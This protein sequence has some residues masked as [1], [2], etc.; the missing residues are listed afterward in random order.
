MPAVS[1]LPVAS[2]SLGLPPDSAAAAASSAQPTQVQSARGPAR[3]AQPA[4]AAAAEE[5]NSANA[6]HRRAA[7]Q[8]SNSG[9]HDNFDWPTAQQQPQSQTLL[10]TAQQ[11]VQSSQPSATAQAASQPSTSSPQGTPA[12]GGSG[13]SP[14]HPAA[15][16][17]L[18]QRSLSSASSDGG[19]PSASP[20]PLTS[21][22]SGSGGVELPPDTTVYMQGLLTKKGR[23]LGFGLGFWRTTRLYM[24]TDTYLGWTDKSQKTC[25]TQ[26]AVEKFKAVS[27]L[28]SRRWPN[29]CFSLRFDDDNKVYHLRAPT[30]QECTDWIEALTKAIHNAEKRKARWQYMRDNAQVQMAQQMAQMGPAASLAL[31]QQAAAQQQFELMGMMQMPVSPVIYPMHVAQMPLQMAQMPLPT[32]YSPALSH[33]P[34]AAQ[35]A[36]YNAAMLPPLEP[37]SSASPLQRMK[38][39]PRG[40]AGSSLSRQDSKS[41]SNSMA[42]AAAHAAAAAGASSGMVPH[43]DR[44]AASSSE[45]DAGGMSTE[46]DDDGEGDSCASADELDGEGGAASASGE[47]REDDDFYDEASEEEA[48]DAYYQ[49]NRVAGVGMPVG[50]GAYPYAQFSAAQ[51]AAALAQWQQAQ[52]QAQQQAQQQ[53]AAAA[54]ESYATPFGSAEDQAALNRSKDRLGLLFNLVAILSCI[55]LLSG[56]E[57]HTATQIGAAMGR[58]IGAGGAM[59]NGTAIAFP[60]AIPS[61]FSFFTSL[62]LLSSLL[63]SPSS[64]LLCASLLLTVFFVLRLRAHK[65]RMKKRQAAKKEEEARA[66]AAA[67][68]AGHKS[69]TPAEVAASQ[70]KWKEE[71]KLLQ[72]EIDTTTRIMSSIAGSA[73]ASIALAVYVWRS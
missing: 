36:A 10:Q 55:I 13:S 42:A 43:A 23:N 58:V 15:T 59:G 57:G 69:P 7:T 4:P 60:S 33:M 44:G 22:T 16:A 12:S 1:P 6:L 66:K 65:R 40:G 49:A 52:L 39:R 73:V 2:M 17:G 48:P 29:R 47:E 41:K 45:M 14:L 51:Q 34:Y 71:S 61:L 30:V 3:T 19:A 5:S 63:S 20:L 56:S 28:N 35:P 72:K 21:S 46:D 67:G 8:G 11:T 18:G 64:V 68:A 31:Q 54:Y 27:R 53:A 37:S 26:I 24:L 32:I 70:A 62:P 9:A 50:V 38:S 25:K